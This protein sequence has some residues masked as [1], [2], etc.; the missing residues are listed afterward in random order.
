MNSWAPPKVAHIF[1]YFGLFYPWLLLFN[2]IFTIYWISDRSYFFIVPLL[3]I[4]LGWGHIKSIVG[5]NS[6]GNRTQ[7]GKEVN[8]VCHNL[9]YLKNFYEGD[10]IMEGEELIKRMKNS[11][12]DIFCFQEFPRFLKNPQELPI[13]ISKQTSFRYFKRFGKSDLYVFSKFPFKET[14]GKIFNNKVNGYQVLDIDLG[15]NQKL[16]VFNV[17]FASNQVSVIADKIAKG[18][19]MGE[20]EKV[21][22]FLGM[23]R[24][25]RRSAITRV[26]QGQEVLELVRSSS[27]PVIV[28]GDFNEVPQSYIFNQFRKELSDSFSEKGKGFGF[29]YNGRFPG[30]RIDYI[31][32]SKELNLIESRVLPSDFSDHRQ[33]MTVFEIKQYENLQ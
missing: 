19:E 13:K 27:I 14:G 5:F 32:A 1:I 31:F 15:D 16:K 26:E 8:I 30:L 20:S 6:K 33:V 9:H 28:A 29:S 11:K 3:I 17:H 21:K 10:K 25:Y 7:E 12:A 4:A 22:S 24:H 2:I 23:L 18:P